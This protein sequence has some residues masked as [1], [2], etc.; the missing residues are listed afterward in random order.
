M[1][2]LC[3]RPDCAAVRAELADAQAYRT[4]GGIPRPP[5]TDWANWTLPA[6]PSATDEAAPEHRRAGF[7]SS[8]PVSD[9]ADGRTT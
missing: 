2:G 9:T 3:P 1:T 6:P 5:V 4:L 7:A 8:L